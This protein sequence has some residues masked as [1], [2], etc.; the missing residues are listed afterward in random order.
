LNISNKILIINL[1]NCSVK[2]EII[3]NDVLNKFIGGR[4]LNAYLLLKYIGNNIDAYDSENVIAISKGMLTGTKALS[5]ARI[6]VSAVSPITNIMGT[7]NA[8]GFFGADMAIDD[9]VS[10]VILGKA[11]EPAYIYI[12]EN[13]V[14]IRNAKHI[15]GSDV[16]GSIKLIKEDCKNENARVAV[17]GTAGEKLVSMANVMF[18]A[19]SAAGR[20]G[21]GAVMGSKNLKAI[22][23]NPSKKKSK[24]KSENTA[25][26]IKKHLN[27][28]KEA[29]D[30]ERWSKFA[31][32]T[33]VKW[34]DD[35]GASPAFNYQKTHFEGVDTASGL[36]FKDAKTKYISCY[37]C[38]IHCKAKIE[39]DHG[40]H[41][42]FL[43]DR[44][45]F[46]CMEA[47]GPKCGNDDA[48]ESLYLH[49][50][51]NKLGMDTIETGS[52]I[53]FAI[54]LYERGILTKEETKGLHLEWGNNE[55][56]EK[57]LEQIAS[58]NSWLGNVL[59]QGIRKSAKIIGKGAEKFAFHVK[60][61]AM[62]S[63]D[64]RG[65]NGTGLGYAIGSRGADFCNT[66]PSLE[67]GYESRMPKDFFNNKE[68]ENRFSPEGKGEMVSYTFKIS[69]IMDSIGL[70]KIPYLS[71][72]NDF[73]LKIPSELIEALL[74]I[75]ITPGQLL[76]CGERIINAERFFNIRQGL[77]KSDDT[78]PDKF[79]TQPIK[80]GICKGAV[81]D[82]EKMLVD[83]Y[84][85]MN[86]SE[87][88]IPNKTIIEEMNLEEI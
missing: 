29:P 58:R 55:A 63:M 25:K 9:I 65:F 66:Y 8:G 5:S 85:Q 7:S 79:L 74:G 19:D 44:P 40:R 52:A 86:W 33:D 20:T 34:L 4:G 42:G 51:C 6:Q 3:T 56:M 54:D 80:E 22:A 75:K 68:A 78:L 70:C 49:T 53:A 71:L 46:E 37:M 76:K 30:F 26:I 10:I 60:G 47:F 11:K 21:M 13:N 69:A 35:F 28:I 31:D 12:Q 64:P 83:F 57:L 67:C 18:G 17:I 16:E 39:V 72:L 84:L 27:L 59:A 1:S 24:G 87:E 48:F 62:T 38:P 50:M 15:W 2:K 77:K 14:E 23:I 61:L 41:K 36:S 45:P 43:G 88:G 73:G 32:S 81:V 82:I